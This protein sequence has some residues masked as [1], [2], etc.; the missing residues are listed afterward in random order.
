MD[1]NMVQCK[2]IAHFA[3]LSQPGCRGKSKL[4]QNLN[5]PDKLGEAAT[6]NTVIPTKLSATKTTNRCLTNSCVSYA[7]LMHRLK[8]STTLTRIPGR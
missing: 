2:T 6:A 8:N 5:A 4:K 3:G 1:R 7:W